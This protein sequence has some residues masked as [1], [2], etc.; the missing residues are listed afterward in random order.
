MMRCIMYG[1]RMSITTCHALIYL[2][3]HP[4]LQTVTRSTEVTA[5]VLA[6]YAEEIFF[7]NL[8]FVEAVFFPRIQIG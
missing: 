2:S 3:Y 1:G 8:T 6:S 7:E 5:F 4:N